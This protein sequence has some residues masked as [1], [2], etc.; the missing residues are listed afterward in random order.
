MSLNTIIKE[1]WRFIKDSFFKIIIGAVI[2]AFISIGIVFLFDRMIP[3]ALTSAT[4]EVNTDDS[5]DKSDA[6]ESR[7]YLREIFGIEPASFQIYVQVADGDPFTNSF[8]FDEYYTSYPF[9]SEISKNSDFQLPETLAHEERLGHKKTAEYRGSIAGIRDTSTHVITFRVQSESTAAD[10][11]RLAE[12]IFEDI[13]SQNPSFL[14]DADITVIEPPQ[15]KEFL[16]LPDSLK[17]PTT[18][19]SESVQEGTRSG[20]K[21]LIIIIAGF[22]LGILVSTGILLISQIFKNKINY[23]FQYAWDFDDYHLLIH[24]QNQ[25]Q[26]NEL[27]Q[28]PKAINR[29]VIVD[30]M[31]Q[32][33]INELIT[34]NTEEIVILVQAKETS[35]SW[36]QK[37][38]ELASMVPCQIKIIHH[39]QTKKG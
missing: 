19:D 10:N 26:I 30:G 8:I 36:Y 32:K 17:V 33:A 21:I 6:K 23:A 27:I 39:V 13:V 34:E 14:S 29:A 38:Y 22:I 25:E 15:N 4:I 35:K 3:N 5:V 37:A 7:D 9:V 16:T 18:P 1:F 31:N 24:D 11:L 2:F 12:L 20:R 28:Y